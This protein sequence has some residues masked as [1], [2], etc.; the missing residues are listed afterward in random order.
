MTPQEMAELRRL[1]SAA[2][3]TNW[4]LEVALMRR[5][6]TWFDSDAEWIAAC[7]PDRITA[8]LDRIEE[9]EGALADIRDDLDMSRATGQRPDLSDLSARITS[10]LGG[11][12]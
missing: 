1:A 4:A 2:T 3:Q 6:A 7:S 5:G 10:L 11:P 8:L 9:L 12:A